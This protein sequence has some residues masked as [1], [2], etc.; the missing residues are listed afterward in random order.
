MFYIYLCA[1]VTYIKTLCYVMLFT[2]NALGNTVRKLQSRHQRPLP[3]PAAAV[4]SMQ[5]MGRPLYIDSNEYGGMEGRNV[6]SRTSVIYFA[7]TIFTVSHKNSWLAI[8][9]AKKQGRRSIVTY[10][11]PHPS[12]MFH[13]DPNS[14]SA[15]WLFIKQIDRRFRPSIWLAHPDPLT[16][17]NH[18][19]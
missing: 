7:V 8:F 19:L 4:S 12:P 1:F 10:N 14:L 18:F 16:P 13:H 2:Y 5:S 17:A 9:T 15:I 11:L 3:P 6:V